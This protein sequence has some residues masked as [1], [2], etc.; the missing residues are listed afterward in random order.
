MNQ[1]NVPYNL[2][3]SFTPKPV[4]WSGILAEAPLFLM[5]WVQRVHKETTVCMKQQYPCIYV[6]WE[7]ITMVAYNFGTKAGELSSGPV[8]HLKW[9]SCNTQVNE[10]KLILQIG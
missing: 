2:C 7:V 9:T 5:L 8:R 10:A 3:R 6:P 4:L 1:I